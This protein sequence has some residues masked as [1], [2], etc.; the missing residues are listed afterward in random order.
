M[1]ESQA[2]AIVPGGD[3]FTLAQQLLTTG[4]LPKAVDTPAKA[5]AIILTGKEMGLGPMES[6]RTIDVIQGKPAPSGKLLLAMARQRVPGLVVN[7][8][9]ATDEACEVEVIRPEP[10]ETPFRF[11]FTIDDAK[12]LDLAGKD[13]YKKQ[14]RTMLMWRA[15]SQALRFKCPEALGGLYAKEELEFQDVAPVQVRVSNVDKG[16]PEAALTATAAL[17]D[18]A[19]ASPGDQPLSGEDAHESG[20]VLDSGLPFS[21]DAEASIWRSLLRMEA[22][23]V[24]SRLTEQQFWG[25]VTFYKNPKDGKESVNETRS[26]AET[27]IRKWA[28]KGWEKKFMGAWIGNARDLFMSDVEKKAIAFLRKNGV[29]QSVVEDCLGAAFVNLTD[30]QRELVNRAATMMKQESISFKDAFAA[31]SRG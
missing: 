8:P 4:F 3:L 7:F 24:P 21:S 25:Q 22:A 11:R 12:K 16:K 6:L 29:E 23:I 30:A 20:E 28:E 5:V 14:A 19:P 31:A 9:E 27:R 15:C 10:G 26:S 17:A 13:N 1:S 2:I 18:P